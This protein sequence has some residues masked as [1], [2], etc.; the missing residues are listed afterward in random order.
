MSPVTSVTRSATVIGVT[1]HIIDIEA[2]L[3]P[4]TPGIIVHG[5]PAAARVR[6]AVES[7][8][9]DLAR[10]VVIDALPD[11][12]PKHGGG[13]DL[14]LAVAALAAAGK[15]PAGTLDGVFFYAGLSEHLGLLRPVRGTVPAV[16]VIAEAGT[17]DGRPPAVVVDE[18]NAAEAMAVPGV[19]VVPARN[20]AD[21]TTWLAGGPAPTASPETRR[22]G[23][24]YPEPGLS[25]FTA[26]PGA[27]RA[28]IIAA[29]GA[30]HMRI[31]APEGT[32]PGRLAR[33]A[34]NLMP[35]LSA[36]DDLDVTAAHSAAGTLEPGTGLLTRPVF[37]APDPARTT[38]PSMLGH[39]QGGLLLPG[40]AGLA[41]RGML[42]LNMTPAAPFRRDVLQALHQPADVGVAGISTAR[43]Q[44]DFPAKLILAISAPGCPCSAPEPGA[45][46]CSLKQLNAWRSRLAAL[47]GGHSLVRAG[48]RP[49]PAGPDADLFE[50]A[51]RGRVAEARQRAARRLDGTG[52]QVN[53]EVPAT[54]IRRDF[55]LA[56]DGAQLLEDAVRIGAA[57]PRQADGIARVAWTIAD[58]A[59]H[60]RPDGTDCREALTACLKDPASPWLGKAAGPV[61]S[62]AAGRP[63]ASTRRTARL[64]QV[65]PSRRGQAL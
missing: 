29:A 61:A 57:S 41:H 7:A 43:A 10:R 47:P 62:L 34:W 39:N 26:S 12:L 37:I 3:A 50:T 52:W 58:L 40:Y 19:T 33:A 45:C 56:G 11:S 46:T 32:S 53:A 22:P 31:T 9:G 16:R 25:E 4:G 36:P 38:M 54:V 6:S 21:I 65:P 14:A 23:L 24:S 17:R 63:Q 55:R 2:G 27:A 15:M 20:L 44:A 35:N 60:D 48:L 13:L 1:A 8:A 49:G 59:G 28:A 5:R 42:F 64:R 30:H 18:H 51:A